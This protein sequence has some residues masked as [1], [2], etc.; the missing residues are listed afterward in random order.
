MGE[1]TITVRCACGWE[2]TGPEE[3]V[4]TDTIDHGRKTHN[5]VATRDDVIAMAVPKTETAESQE[6]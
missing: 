5:M 2:R 4:V 6:G 3:D 1:E